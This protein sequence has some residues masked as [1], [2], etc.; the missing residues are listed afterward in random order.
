MNRVFHLNNV[1]QTET[2]ESETTV[3]IALDWTPN[4]NH[5]GLYIA[6]RQGLYSQAGLDVQILPPDVSYSTTPAK[7]LIAGE[8]DLAIV[9]SE[10]CIAYAESDK[11]D[12]RLQAIY[13]ILQSD[14]SAIVSTSSDFTRPRNLENG[15]YGSYNAKYE[16]HIIRAMVNADGGDGTKIQIEGSKGKLSLFEE[17]KNGNIDATWI[18][19]PWEGVQAKR[20]GVKLNVFRTEEHDVPYGYSPVIVRNGKQGTL[21]SEVLS[22]FVH[23]T[24]NGYEIA[25]KTPEAAVDALKGYCEEDGEFL[26]DSQQ[27]INQFYSDGK[28]GRL[29]SIDEEKW[30]KWIRWLKE[31]GLLSKSAG[32]LDD[33]FTNEF[34]A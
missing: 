3:K 24:R 19:M 17:L 8:V 25:L 5:S 33:L 26:L 6:Q 1:E 9:P 10:S 34:Q 32:T 23:T 28:G 14:A 31:Q 7:R 2:M 21:P 18:F 20:D 4:T 27:Q 30:N 16:D 22:K 12:M 11:H 29:G 15:R 13:A